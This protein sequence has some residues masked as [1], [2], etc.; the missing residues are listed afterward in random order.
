MDGC[1]PAPG[2]D[3]LAAWRSDLQ[4]LSQTRAGP[5]P[6]RVWLVELEVSLMQKCSAAAQVLP[7]AAVEGKQNLI[8]SCIQNMYVLPV[9]LDVSDKRRE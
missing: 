1:S 7:E 9:W 5:V 6:A 4:S 8:F 2:T 3:P